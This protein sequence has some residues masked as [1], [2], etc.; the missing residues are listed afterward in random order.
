VITEYKL[1]VFEL[2]RFVILLKSG[3]MVYC[4]IS[5]HFYTVKDMDGEAT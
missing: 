2:E 5:G 1:R 4:Y 3:M